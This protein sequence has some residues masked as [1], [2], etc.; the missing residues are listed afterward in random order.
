[1]AGTAWTEEEIGRKWDRCF[2]DAI[3]KL[4]GGIF[5]GSVVSLLFFRR[6]WPIVTGAAFGLGLAY[7]NCEKDINATIAL[8]VKP[9]NSKPSDKAAKH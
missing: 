3:F 4:G 5:L 7:S 2:A 9:A 8:E 1:M 6:K